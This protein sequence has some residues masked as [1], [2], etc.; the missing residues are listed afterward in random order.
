MIG[1]GRVSAALDGRKAESEPL[2]MVAVRL[3][4]LCYLLAY[5]RNMIPQMTGRKC[6]SAVIEE[7]EFRKHCAFL[8]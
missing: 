7:D 4:M 6:F 2:V 3:V 5:V 8:R 1:W